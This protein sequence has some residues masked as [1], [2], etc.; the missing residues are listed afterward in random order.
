MC[1]SE[2]LHPDTLKRQGGLH[3]NRY[4]YVAVR[5]CGYC[6]RDTSLVDDVSGLLQSRSSAPFDLMH[7]RTDSSVCFPGFALVSRGGPSLLL[8]LLLMVMMLAVD[9][10]Q[11]LRL[12]GLRNG[13]GGS[14]SWV[15]WMEWMYDCISLL[16]LG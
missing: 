3:I 6:A 4:A 13:M 1:K 8:L 2:W 7:V 10:G 14:F 16:A 9:N 5:S 12:A 11:C 15:G